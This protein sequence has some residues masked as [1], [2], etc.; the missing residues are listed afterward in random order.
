MAR[1]FITGVAGFIGSSLAKH[2]LL[3]GHEVAGVDN[4][5]TGSLDNLN[6]IRQDIEFHCADIRNQ[7]KM[8]GYCV[9]VDTVFHQAALPSVPKSVIDPLSSHLA[10][11][12]GTFNLL[13]A[14]R[15]A[16]VRRVL[17]AASSSAYGESATSPKREDM[18]TAPI[19]PY[20]VQKLTG[21]H[22]MQS[23]ARVYGMETVCLRYF[24]VFGPNQ[25]ADSPYSGVLAKF[26]TAMLTGASPTIYG[27]GS[28]SRDFTYIQN[29]VD[30][31]MLA[32]EAP[33][34]RVS[35]NVY[36]VACGES[37]TLMETYRL[38]AGMVGHGG[39]PIF[40]TP[41]KGDIQHS[42]ADIARA[43]RDLGYAPTIDFEEGLRRTIAWY[44]ESL[45]VDFQLADAA[46]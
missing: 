3:A 24:N 25:A 30:A 44:A 5:T 33:A 8:R 35:G 40:T 42:L 7:E 22:Y 38:I 4:L 29:V 13:L 20:A 12:D 14:A 11:I 15:D 36:N 21:E 10:N 9:G 41:R 1:M 27:D 37:H 19:S 17:Y 45:R 28:Q 43:E 6:G 16:G 18:P 26:I 46:V 34:E 32:A 23:F 31:N 39:T 2:L